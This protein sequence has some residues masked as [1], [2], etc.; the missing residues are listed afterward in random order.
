MISKDLLSLTPGN[1]VAVFELDTGPIGGSEI[2]RFFTDTNPIG[3]TLKWGGHPYTRFPIEASGFERTGSGTLPR[4]KLVVA[5][6]DGIIGQLGRSYGGLE[7]AKITRTRTFVK[8]L[9]AANFPGGV[10]PSADP[11]QYI[12]RE[13]WFVARRSSE[14]RIFIEYELSAS[15][16]LGNVKLPRRQIIQNVCTWRY[17]SSECGY[18]GG[19][20]ANVKDEPVT[21]LS[22]DHCGKRLASCK[23]RHGSNAVLPYGGFPGAGLTRG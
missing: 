9:D 7:G 18:T 14:N 12:D 22:L 4:P 11:G 15:F 3:E 21:E 13:I 5:N 17:R 2:L 19:P 23:L 6:V 16:D 1:L 8:Y 20:C 10:N